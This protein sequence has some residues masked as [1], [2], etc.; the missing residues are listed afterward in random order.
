[1]RSNVD[2][3]S[4][5]ACRLVVAGCLLAALP[6]HAVVPKTGPQITADAL[7][8]LPAAGTA[9]P[10]RIER[11][12]EWAQ[13]PSTAWSGFTQRHAGDWQ[14]G[15]D[16]ATG[17]P[18]RIWGPGIAAPGSVADA[19]TAERF[20]RQVLA[21]ELGLLAPGSQPSDFELVSNQVKNG[22]R[23]VG[24]IQRAG[25]LH[26][27]GGQVSFR[28]K[29]D[30]LFM[31]GSEALPN[32][33]VAMP[34]VK[35]AIRDF[36]KHA[37]DLLRDA[38]TL[39]NAPVSAPGDL[40]I[41]PLVADDAVLGY[42]V[43]RPLTIDGGG[44][45]RYLAYADAATGSI[46]AVRQLNAYA[47]GVVNYHVVNRYPENGPRVDR[48]AKLAHVLVNGV[49]QT[50]TANGNVTWSDGEASVETSTT[51][52]LV[53]VVNKAMGNVLASALYAL[54]PDSAFAWDASSAEFDDAQVNAYVATMMAKDWVR[55]NLDAAMPTLDDVIPV[56]VNIANT[57]NAFFDGKAINF[58]QANASCQNTALIQDVVFHEYGHR[59]HTA[60]IIDGVGDFDGA[61][62]EGAADFLAA[63]I[64]G[65]AGMGRGFFH[66]SEALRDL[67]PKDHEWLW[68]QD[69][70]EIHHTGMIFG[71]A[72]WDL[73]TGL[74]ADLGE[75]AA[76][77][78]TN[79]LYLGALR[80][81]TGI[82]DVLLE[83]LAED[84][85]DGDLSNGTPH[86]CTIR[87]AFGRHG[88]RTASGVVVAP[89]QLTVP[90]LAVGIQI[91][92]LGVS[93]RCNLDQVQTAFID[94]V[95][96]FGDP[97]AGTAEATSAGPNAFYAQ[98]PL[99]QQESIFYKARVKFMDGSTMTLA[100]NLADPY[101]Q[102]YQGRTVK[103]YCTN[104]DDTDPFADGW[105]TGTDKAD[106]PSPFEWGTPTGGPSDPHAAY[107]GTKVLAQKLDGD[108]NPK[109]DAWVKMPVIDIGQYSD[110]RLQYRRWLGVE[111]G[112]FDKAQILAN[113]KKAWQNYDSNL[114]DSSAIHHI[115]REWR[116]HDVPLS[117]YVRGHNLQVTFDLTSDEGLELGG[118]QLDDVCIV[119]NPYSICGDGVKSRTEQCDNGTLN[120]DVADTCH[121]DCHMPTC[122]DSIVD[123]DEECDEGGGTD[124]CSA[125]CK[126]LQQPESGCCSSSGGEGSLG[127]SGIVAIF[128]LRRRRKAV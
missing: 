41:L 4:V 45:G 116:F 18:S 29:A 80:R 37:N 56:N 40:V 86:E 90:A 65:D 92:V 124:S 100:D 104:F 74:I 38:V 126:I 11:K 12:I 1:M 2:S 62:S 26:V 27:I 102:L 58:F 115:D 105:T 15:W 51:G 76:L 22:M 81:S 120:A 14:A 48:P 7:T 128:L 88:L 112:H 33:S 9:K 101:Y 71:G 59:V 108:Y 95:P 17:V 60:E 68:P 89:G 21:D 93:S 36:S 66:N 87:A 117:T 121:T 61:M 75:A 72:F 110:V 24:F 20:A 23:T 55:A 28:F 19:A 84:D 47:T 13:T 63:S 99:A 77:P 3:M 83:V 49:G 46:L 44:N 78:L 50:T 25:G 70:G 114:G 97:H 16:R 98:L 94:W 8:A 5:R 73:R 109:Q 118:W 53:T 123:S 64:T 85:D 31:I 54:Q 6:A 127:L 125:T 119:A 30:R 122:G 113:G 34:R 106:S 42:R 91:K 103:L 82:P 107:S 43:A 10:L 52:D 39:P 111:D 35:L 79:T 57:C 32:V 69:I 67:D 96:P